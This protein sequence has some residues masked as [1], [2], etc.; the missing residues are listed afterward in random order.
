MAFLVMGSPMIVQLHCKGPTGKVSRMRVGVGAFT[1]GPDKSISN[2]I[3]ARI[4]QDSLAH[5][6]TDLLASFLTPLLKK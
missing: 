1:G 4:P 6:D 3:P 5:V 2:R